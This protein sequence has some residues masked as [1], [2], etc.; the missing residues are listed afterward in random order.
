MRMIGRRRPIPVPESD[1]EPAPVSALAI[2]LI[3]DPEPEAL[4]PE[5]DTPEPEEVDELFAAPPP[6]PPP[7][8]LEGAVA[9]AR[10]AVA[11][12]AAPCEA[13]AWLV[14]GEIADD[15]PPPPEFAP[16]LGLGWFPPAPGTVSWY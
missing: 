1:P 8:A 5:V 6:F 13:S 3:G 10:F 14:A 9:L 11:A 4:E 12:P 16:P 2:P 15:P 7:L